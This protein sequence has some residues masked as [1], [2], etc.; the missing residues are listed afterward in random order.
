MWCVRKQLYAKVKFLIYSMCWHCGAELPR[1]SSTWPGAKRKHLDFSTSTLNQ[2]CR[3]SNSQS[4][5]FLVKFTEREREREMVGCFCR[6][7]HCNGKSIDLPLSD[8]WLSTPDSV[9]LTGHYLLWSESWFNCAYYSV[10]MLWLPSSELE[11]TREHSGW[12]FW[13]SSEISRHQ[14]S[15]C[16]QAIGP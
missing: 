3:T 2:A 14:Q 1:D 8:Y 7:Y 11:P 15:F 13:A 6:K 9:V 5:H 4:R 16:P 12:I 10:I